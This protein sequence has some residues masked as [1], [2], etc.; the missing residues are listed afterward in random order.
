LSHVE[1]QLI[2]DWIRTPA[3]TL[4]LELVSAQANRSRRAL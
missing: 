3:T 2:V 1:D 4:A